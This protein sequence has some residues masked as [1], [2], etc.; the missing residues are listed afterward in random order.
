MQLQIFEGRE[1]EFGLKNL[2]T[3]EINGGIWFLAKEVCW[4]LDLK[5]IPSVLGRLDSD[6]KIISPMPINGS[7][8]IIIS[9]SGL[10]TLVFASRKPTEEGY[11]CVE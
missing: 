8:E 6:E 3:I 11:V 2:T 1:N 7:Q 10:Y 4:A 5:D 9:E